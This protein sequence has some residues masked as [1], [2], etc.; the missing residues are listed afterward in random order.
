MTTEFDDLKKIWDAQN[1]QPLYVLDEKAIYNRIQSKM[2]TIL[3][4]ANVSDWVLI[5]INLGVGAV[6]LNVNSATPAAKLFLHLEAAWM[7]VT[8]V[9]FIVRYIRRVKFGRRFDRSIHGDL[10]HAIFLTSYQMRIA[11]IVRWN[12]IPAG[13]LMIFSGW[14]AGKLLQVGAII[15]ISNT[16]AFYVCTKGYGTS[17]RRKQ[18]LEVLKGKLESSS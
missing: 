4:L 12:L 14:E 16:L 7:F 2:T 18:E 6:L 1:N 5:M 13:V 11:Q 8:G 9:Y 15:L 17:K 3:H 10:D